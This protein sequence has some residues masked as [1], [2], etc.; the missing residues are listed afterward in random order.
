MCSSIWTMR[1]RARW[2]ARQRLT[3]RGLVAGRSHG[4]WPRWDC[5]RQS[6]PLH[7]VLTGI[8]GT[9]GPVRHLRATKPQRAEHRT[10]AL[11]RRSTPC[12]CRTWRV[13]RGCAVGAAHGRARRDAVSRHREC[14]RP[15]RSP[16]SQA[17][18]F[19][20]GGQLKRISASGGPA[21]V[22]SE[23]V[24]P[25]APGPVGTWNPRGDILFAQSFG[26]LLRVSAD[27]GTPTPATTVDATRHEFGHYNPVFLA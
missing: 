19:F 15:V 11:S 23:A 3:R 13:G 12:V 27:G 25:A 16:D 5:R 9:P 6:R 10:R 1:R 20:A 24:A 14:V 2:R 7:F 21:H 8:T 26:P 22:L 18:A 4:Q 17:I